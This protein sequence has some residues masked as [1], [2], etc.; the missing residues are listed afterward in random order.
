MQESAVRNLA[1]NVMQNAG[2]RLLLISVALMFAQPGV[3]SA[4]SQTTSNTNQ[5]QSSRPAVGDSIL[6]MF[7]RAQERQALAQ[8]D[9][10][11]YV[12]EAKQGDDGSLALPEGVGGRCFGTTENTCSPYAIRDIQL[13][14][15]SVLKA[16]SP[17]TAEEVSL[18]AGINPGSRFFDA[19][20]D[21]MVTAQIQ[22]NG[23]LGLDQGA[24]GMAIGNIHPGNIFYI[25][26]AMA[27][28]V[29]EST[30]EA[31]AGRGTVQ[32][33]REMNQ[34]FNYL[35]Q[36]TFS[37]TV[38]S[39][40]YQYSQ[41]PELFKYDYTPSRD[42]DLSNLE[43]RPAQ[44]RAASGGP[45]GGAISASSN[46]G[47]ASTAN[48]SGGSSSSSSSVGSGGGSG[49]GGAN[50]L[51]SADSLTSP[52]DPLENSQA[53]AIGMGGNSDGQFIMTGAEIIFDPENL[54]L[55]KHR[56]EGTAIVDGQ[57][58]DIFIETEFWDFRNPPGC[59]DMDEPYMSARRVGGILGPQ[60][61][62]QLAEAQAQ[63]AEFE[64][65]LADVPP[66]QRAMVERMLGPQ[67]E[68]VRNLANSG[69]IEQV[70]EIERITCNP[71]WKELYGGPAVPSP[72]AEAQILAEGN[73]IRII[74]E[75]LVILGYEPGNIDGTLDDLT[76]VAISQFQAE[77]G[78]PVDG[79]PSEELA[80]ALLEAVD[81]L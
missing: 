56:V 10:Q 1:S 21:S 35:R 3:V 73:L 70:Q 44:G 4:Q 64:R 11:S 2:V 16:R 18:L 5:Q 26:A 55:I 80:A 19:M 52:N 78:L 8:G 15:G 49:V 45:A 72:N 58:R 29:A 65:Q 38:R 30:M 39:D 79:E 24:Q 41:Y 28:G 34:T 62:A 68:M 33:Q 46:S 53:V 9:V 36:T 50:Q 51:V 7:V 77:H 48:S 69:T 75:Y 63:M 22:I 37:E 59:A 27:Y 60:E 12:Y 40:D 47:S 42:L 57:S 14:D 67:M 32:E 25:G 66:Q 6:P 54:R 61:M 20:G 76:I 43:I 74:Q 13:D 81:I 31:M 71:D 23:F 17:L